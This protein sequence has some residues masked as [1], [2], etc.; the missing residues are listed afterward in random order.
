MFFTT[1][2]PNYKAEKTN[3][4]FHVAM[5]KDHKTIASALYVLNKHA[6]EKRNQKNFARIC[7]K[8]WDSDYY[9]GEVN[10]GISCYEAEKHLEKIYN[11]KNKVMDKLIKSKSMKYLGFTKT[12]N[13]FYKTS[14]WACYSFCKISFHLQIEE[15]KGKKLKTIGGQT[16][17]AEIDIAK[18]RNITTHQAISILSNFIS[19]E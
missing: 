3:Q 17:E 16:I 15:P 8:G 4:F 10:D 5:T 6:K 13:G 11:L 1:K 14:Y 18:S 2:K 7:E 9:S 12:W 19:L